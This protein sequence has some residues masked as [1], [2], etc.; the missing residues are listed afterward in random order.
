MIL[1]GRYVSQKSKRCTKGLNS[2]VLD[3]DNLPRKELN[4][5]TDNPRK[6]G[7]AVVTPHAY[8][9]KKV[10][11]NKAAVEANKQQIHIILAEDEAQLRQNS[12]SAELVSDGS[13]AGKEQVGVTAAAQQSTAGTISSS[14]GVSGEVL[15]DIDNPNCEAASQ[16]SK[17]AANKPCQFQGHPAAKFLDAEGNYI[18][19]GAGRPPFIDVYSEGFDKLP[20]DVQVASYQRFREL[21]KLR[22]SFLKKAQALAKK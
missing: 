8:H 1:E 2:T 15:A 11:R 19:G 17:K 21:S 4:L 18:G 3:V 14:V 12:V 9:S 6:F 20:L 22:I 16:I 10:G 5:V 7:R 13:G